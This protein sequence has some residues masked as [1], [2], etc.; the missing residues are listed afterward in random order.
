MADR[1]F[2][3]ELQRTSTVATYLIP[4]FRGNWS[5]AVIYEINDWVSF[6]GSVFAATRRTLAGESPIGAPSKWQLVTVKG[7][8]GDKGEPG[9]RG[10]Q[11]G[12]GPQGT[13]GDKGEMGPPGQQGSPGP[14]GDLGGTLSYKGVWSAATNYTQADAVTVG[15]TT[16]ATFSNN[17]NQNPATTPAVWY[18]VAVQGQT[19]PQGATG[20]TG[21]TGQTGQP[22]AKGDKGDTGA[23]GPAGPIGPQG[24]AGLNGAAGGL[25]PTGPAGATGPAGPA[26]LNGTQLP[27][28]TGGTNN[29]SVK[30]STSGAASWVDVVESD[31][32]VDFVA[33]KG[34]DG[35]IYPAGTVAPIAGAGLT[36]NTK[37]MLKNPVG[38]GPN[39]AVLGNPAPTPSSTFTLLTIGQTSSDAAYLYLYPNPLPLFV[40]VAV[41]PPQLLGEYKMLQTVENNRIYDVTGTASRA[42]KD[43]DPVKATFTTQ[44]LKITA[45]TNINVEAVIP[46]SIFT[47]YIAG[48]RDNSTVASTILGTSDVTGAPHGYWQVNAAGGQVIYGAN[49]VA[50]TINTVSNANTAWPT[51]VLKQWCLVVNGTDANVYDGN[52]T[53]VATFAIGAPFPALTNFWIGRRLFT[54]TPFLGTIEYFSIYHA[55]HNTSDRA[56]GLAKMTAGIAGRP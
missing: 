1:S 22:G 39:L 53:L 23:A 10:E 21:A 27:T 55:A 41:Y 29:R 47:V 17:I 3:S 15:G 4:Q 26:G 20:A 44:G 54:G 35:K 49:T 5:A 48:I 40:S 51:G 42:I 18:P 36:A 2:T 14:K 6:M 31:Q 7:D 28:L 33:F 12:V 38:P 9:E 50:G 11:G 8:T 13:P 37:Y 19:G 24:P 43:F 52:N 56:A 45:E 16:Y 32:D 30:P 25:G 46:D 34:S